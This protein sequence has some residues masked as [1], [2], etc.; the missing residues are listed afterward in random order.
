LALPREIEG[1]RNDKHLAEGLGKNT[2]IEIHRVSESAPKPLWPRAAASVAGG[3]IIGS[4]GEVTP[5]F[6]DFYINLPNGDLLIIPD[7]FVVVALL[8]VVLWIFWAIFGGPPSRPASAGKLPKEIRNPE[9]AEHYEEQT[10]RVQALKRKLDAETQLAESQIAA[11]RAKAELQELDEIV[12]H[13]HAKRRA[14]AR[15]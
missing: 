8:V 1:A 4:F 3:I 2:P 12:A 6:A 15:R 13:V 10:A 9:P 5:A 14:K 11:A 7:G